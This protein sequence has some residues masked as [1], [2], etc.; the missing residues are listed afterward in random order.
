MHTHH[1][2]NSLKSCRRQFSVR[3]IFAVLLSLAVPSFG[4][5]QD[6]NDVTL[7]F[8][9][10]QDSIT[11]SL[12]DFKDEKFFI[13]ASIGLV[14]IPSAGISCIGEACPEE[15]RL[16]VADAKVTLTSKDGQFSMAGD[17]IEIDG[18]EYVLA[19]SIGVQRI[20]AGLV[21]C[22]GE[23]CGIAPAGPAV[24]TTVVLTNGGIT[25]RGDLVGFEGDTFILKDEIMGE[26]HISSGEFV[27]SGAGCPPQ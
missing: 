19:T 9:N 24:D 15:T 11:G 22:E 12:K 5:A 3:H 4:I 8:A 1:L 16:Q 26:I 13:E 14:V 25:L 7:R 6:A 17:L 10:G 20:D 23:G 21:T 27:C 18:N 2:F